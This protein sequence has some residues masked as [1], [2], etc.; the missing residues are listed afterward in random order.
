MIREEKKIDEFI[1]REA[2][3][4]KDMLKSGSISKDLV[5]LEIF[6]DNIMSD[7]QIDQSQKEYTENRSKEILK[8]K[9]INISGL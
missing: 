3:G 8:E 7:F 4:I 9:G 6:I 5:T 2:K 1:N